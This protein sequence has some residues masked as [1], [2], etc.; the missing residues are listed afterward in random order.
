MTD[1]SKLRETPETD[2]QAFRPCKHCV[3]HK[4][5]C[6][7]ADFARTLERQRDELA[8]R[9][10]RSLTDTSNIRPTPKADAFMAQWVN[11]THQCFDASIADFLR[12]LER[13]RDEL[14][15]ALRESRIW[16]LL[17]DK[18][19]AHRRLELNEAL[20]AKIKGERE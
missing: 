12:T 2:Y 4:I 17:S 13:Q 1:T 16:L 3:D 14:A 7:P 20:L 18:N 6:V 10:R 5:N 9:I 19:E 15:E 11:E 8:E